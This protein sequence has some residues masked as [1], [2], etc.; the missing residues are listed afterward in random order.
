M[1]SHFRAEKATAAIGYLVKSTG[2]DLYSVMKMLYLADKEH[3]QCYGRTISGDQYV[4]M[5]KGPVP[6]RAYNLC[7]FIRGQ[8]DHF[9]AMPTAR[10]WL[11]LNHNNFEILREPDLDELS[12]SDVAALDK[13]AS[14][15]KNGGWR[16]VYQA[17]HDDAWRAAWGEA[18]ARSSQCAGM[19][20]DSVASTLPNAAAIIEFLSDSHPG[21]ESDSPTLHH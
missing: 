2:A 8:R 13:A 19:E 5:Q 4:A 17:S 10:D 11:R 14:V 12:N 16:A 1:Q 9:D 3:L 15:Y 7:K 21:E 18:T 6:D 20:L